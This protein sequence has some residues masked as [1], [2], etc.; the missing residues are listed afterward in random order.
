M[1]KK[2]TGLKATISALGPKVQ[3]KK[4][5]IDVEKTEAAVKKIHS[6]KEATKR[7]TIDMPVDIFKTMKIKIIGESTVRDYVLELI[8]NDLKK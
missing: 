7:V 6:T 8:R 5:E 4:S 2:D 1:A 3:V